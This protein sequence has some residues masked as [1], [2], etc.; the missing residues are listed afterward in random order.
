MVGMRYI[1]EHIRIIFLFFL[2][3]GNSNVFA[4]QISELMSRN[5]SYEMYHLDNIYNFSGWVELYNDGHDTLNLRGYRFE[6]ESGDT[7][8]CK[9]SFKI[10]PDSFFVFWFSE[11]NRANHT[12]FKL[13]PEG[14]RI[15]LYNSGGDIVAE[16]TYPMTFANVSYGAHQTVT[17]YEYGMLSRPSLGRRN[18][19]ALLVEVQAGM[20]VFSLPA[21]FYAEPISLTLSPE[22]QGTRIYYTMDGTE[23][24]EADSLLYTDTIKMS[25]NTVVRAICVNDGY[26]PSE[27]V[28]MSYFIGE[29]NIDLPVVSLCVDPKYMF[30][31]D[32]G[33]YVIGNGRYQPI[34]S[35]W[36]QL[37]DANYWG[38]ELRPSN[39]EFF[40]EGKTE[41]LNQELSIGIFGGYSRSYDMKSLK[42]NPSKV[43]GD[44]QLRYAIFQ[45][46]PNLKWKNI[47][48]RSS[49]QDYNHSYMRDGFMQTLIEG[50]MDVDIQAYTPCA[51]FLNGDYWGLM[52]LRERHNEDY[53]YSNYG[54]VEENVST[55][56][57]S[58]SLWSKLKKETDINGD[59]VNTMIDSL[60]DVNELMNFIVARVYFADTDWG[61]NNVTFWSRRDY[62][63]WRVIMYDTDEGF[64]N[65]GD[66]SN[67]NTFSNTGK[68]ECLKF[69]LKNERIRRIL[70]TKFIIHLATTFS[71]DRV[72]SILDSMASRIQTEA[73]FYQDYRKSKG[74]GENNWS[75]QIEKM[76]SF[77]E[78]RPLNVFSHLQEYFNLGDICDIHI[79]SDIKG[80]EFLFNGEKIDTN[81]FLSNCFKGFNFT[82]S[83]LSPEGY[84]FDHWEICDEKSTYIS[85]T[86]GL[87][88]TFDGP[89]I[90]RAVFKEDSLYNDDV[91]HLYL[92]EICAT[93]KQYVDEEGES[94]DWIEIYNA[95]SSPIDLAGMYLSDSRNNLKKWQIP[96]DAPEQTIVGAKSYKIIWADGEVEQGIMHASFSL[97]S[98][99]RETISL[100]INKGDSI[101]VIDSIR[102]ELHEKGETYARSPLF[103]TSEWSK[104]KWPTFAAPNRMLG[105]VLD[106]SR[107][108]EKQ[109]TIEHTGSVNA[110]SQRISLWPNPANDYVSV[111]TPWQDPVSCSII[112]NG[113]L[114]RRLKFNG[115]TVLD[116]RDL[117]AGIYVVQVY[118]ERTREVCYLKMVKK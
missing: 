93:N 8:T 95:G 48:L 14:G 74:L 6:N 56:L 102:Y 94:D 92:N 45:S 101:V 67:L 118:N 63:C 37:S 81:D 53:L 13:N 69:L 26:L 89:T 4:L 7:W 55:N 17:E 42:I 100:S 87:D 83:C 36:T 82:L 84:V 10:F 112:S 29:R 50:R 115:V 78:K 40:D 85:D 79:Y 105:Y 103:M 60:F 43:Y 41:R 12:S 106:I 16:V 110:M 23:P 35:G 15:R 28:T 27:S 107:N 47:V 57:S 76:R 2:L 32:L 33:I 108:D 64:S 114:L 68:N 66:K 34:Y 19:D 80:T 1:F 75:K 72:K 5:I 59:V 71:P 104:T 25:R 21:G 39:F 109:D 3:C 73:I 97:S 51:V 65:S 96:S 49:G 88:V 20:P 38:D 116:V 99:K 31:G 62:E 18:D 86:C 70:Y 24:Y 46:K 22:E 54:L 91:P 11:Q 111:T 52:N 44:N 117:P 9:S 98:S 30:D 77:A 58:S 113:V 61:G 90:F